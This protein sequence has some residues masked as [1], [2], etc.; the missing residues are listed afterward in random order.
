MQTIRQLVIWFNT[1]ASSVA[2]GIQ[3]HFM[4]RNGPPRVSLVAVALATRRYCLPAAKLLLECDESN[5]TTTFLCD[6]PE[7]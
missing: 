3:V 1:M 5:Y 7:Y 4:G 6:P 2:P